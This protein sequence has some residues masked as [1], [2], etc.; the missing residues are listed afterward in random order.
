MVAMV[1]GY[2]RAARFAGLAMHHCDDPSVPCH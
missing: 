1:A 2:P